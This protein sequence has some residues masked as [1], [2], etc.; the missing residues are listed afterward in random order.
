MHD[1]AAP[2][3]E[4]STSQR[5]E[6]TPVRSASALV[7]RGGAWNVLGLLTP[8]L[9]TIVLT[10]FII[11]G[12]GLARYGLFVLAVTISLFLA[13]FDGGIS[14]SAQR[15]FAVY[16]G[17]DDRGAATRLLV[18]LVALVAALGCVLFVALF[19]LGP[20]LLRAL[21]VPGELLPEGEFLLR[22]LSAIVGL[23]LLQQLFA[24]VL[25]AR[26]RF[27]LTSLTRSASYGVY[28]LG[29]FI[30]VQQDFGLRGLALSLVGQ[31]V[32]AVA[33]L[34]P[35]ACRY[36]SLQHVRLL[37]WTE[38]Q[39]FLRYAATVQVTGLL[40]LVNLQADVLI[41]GAFLPVREVGVYSVGGTFAAQLRSIP[42]NVLAPAQAVLGQAYGD[43]GEVDARP[44]F[45]RLQRLWVQGTAGWCAVGLGA[46]YF[47]VTAWLGSEFTT[48]A[49]VATVLLAGYA[50]NLW[51]GM[52]T[53]WLRV[54]GRP[55][56]EARYGLAGVVANVVLTLVLVVPFGLLGVVAATAAGQLIGTAYLLRL[57]RSRYS[58]DLRSFVRDVPVVPAVLATAATVALELLARPAAPGGPLGLVYSGVVAAPAL[59]L[60][61]VALVGP[62][63]AWALLSRA[64]RAAGK[65]TAPAG[66]ARPLVVRRARR[67]RRRGR[68]GSP[69]AGPP[70]RPR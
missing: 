52:A 20:P 24:A 33:V 12:L 66:R 13:S 38:L 47:G 2:V 25:N 4:A 42:L 32:V 29:A 18:T 62:R 46:A 59:V 8:L 39:R 45:E 61:L 68:T 7:L 15:Y 70:R 60:Y 3:A 41:V 44:D 1:P 65:R 49:V 9:T 28:A 64:T 36:L 37:P 30:A 21:D 35:C 11:D 55:E 54:V 40:G 34:L 69:P 53:T 57:V 10:P 23:G 5:T 43:R 56:L 26:H 63:R 51:T 50:I 31:T 14:A 48:S 19:F 17:T 22:T 58:R 27:A 6:E 16:A 67:P